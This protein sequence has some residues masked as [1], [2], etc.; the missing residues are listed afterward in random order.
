MNRDA[1]LA[2]C[3]RPAELASCRKETAR[4][5]EHKMGGGILSAGIAGCKIRPASGCNECDGFKGAP[6]VM[7]YGCPHCHPP[8]LP[9]VFR[10]PPNNARLRPV[11]LVRTRCN[12]ECS[13]GHPSPHQKVLRKKTPTSTAR[14]KSS[15][16]VKP[17]VETVNLSIKFHVSHLLQ[18]K[19]L[20]NLS[21]HSI[22]VLI[23]AADVGTTVLARQRHCN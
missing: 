11:C 22:L 4:V 17:W 3:N 13:W 23:M 12:L 15:P 21:N 18:N 10:H 16:A 1:W 20:C 5:P 19:A 7:T 6:Q 14:H 8:R 9:R 2:Q